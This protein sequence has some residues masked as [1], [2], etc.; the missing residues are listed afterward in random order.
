[1]RG[2]L[3]AL[4]IGVVHLSVSRN[5][6]IK[7]MKCLISNIKIISQDV[8]ILKMSWLFIFCEVYI[9]IIKFRVIEMNLIE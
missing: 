7:L 4:V 3:I 2:L 8:F 9:I 6:K 5:I 1:M